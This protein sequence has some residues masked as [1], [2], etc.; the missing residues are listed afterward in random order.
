MGEGR[1]LRLV[2]E[3]DLDSHSIAHDLIT[4]GITL[5]EVVIEPFPHPPRAYAKIIEAQNNLSFV[6]HGSAK[7]SRSA[8]GKP[9]LEQQGSLLGPPKR[10]PFRFSASPNTGLSAAAGDDQMHRRGYAL[11]AP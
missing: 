9:D 4:K 7:Q 11:A 5:I 1:S 3:F 6:G 2:Y 10:T 8:S